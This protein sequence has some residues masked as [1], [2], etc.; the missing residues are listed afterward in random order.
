LSLLNTHTLK[1]GMVM[2]S[3][4]PQA[5]RRQESDEEV[6]GESREAGSRRQQEATA[7][8]GGRKQ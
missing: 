8:A 3:G 2:S 1:H 5:Q 6:R 4:M 7:A